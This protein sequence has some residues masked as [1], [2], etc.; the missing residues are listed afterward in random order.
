MVSE[1]SCINCLLDSQN[2]LQLPDGRT[3]ALAICAQGKEHL[4][5]SRESTVIDTVVLHYISALGRAE[6]VYDLREILDVYCDFGVSCH[7]MVQRDGTLY[8]LVPEEFKA[9][10]CG[11]SIM[12]EPDNRQSVNDFSVGIELIA[13]PTSGFTPE[14]Y[15]V[16]VNLCRTLGQRYGNLAYV[17]HDG[18]AGAR[19]VAM[20][21]RKEPKGDPGEF[22]DWDY[23]Y[24]EVAK[25]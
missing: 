12:P 9:W 19:A 20:G 6:N 2:T 15:S 11:K 4:W 18:I 25:K 14:Q 5:D 24:T 22:F 13:T 17:G 1:T 23:F 16:V 3:V 21:L 10:H 7:Y 8:R